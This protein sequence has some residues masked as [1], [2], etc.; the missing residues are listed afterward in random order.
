MDESTQQYQ[1][2]PPYNPKD[3]VVEN[4][5]PLYLDLDDETLLKAEKNTRRI[6]KILE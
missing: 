6:P 2:Q 1:G 5:D 4:M 3:G